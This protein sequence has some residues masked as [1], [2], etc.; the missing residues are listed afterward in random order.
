[1]KNLFFSTSILIAEHLVILSVGVAVVEE[2]LFIPLLLF[3]FA[4]SFSLMRFFA[5]LRMEFYSSVNQSNIKNE[6]PF[7]K[8]LVYKSF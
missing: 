3:F 2:S 6:Q 4:T 5:S 7:Q 1:M 8:L